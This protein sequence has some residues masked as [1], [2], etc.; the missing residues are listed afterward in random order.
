MLLT[1]DFAFLAGVEQGKLDEPKYNLP[2]AHEPLY[3][4]KPLGPYEP[5]ILQNFE[6]FRPD[7]NKPVRT[8]FPADVKSQS[9]LRDT[10]KQGHNN[11]ITY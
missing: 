2:S 8:I 5:G 10:T 6:G 7:P 4:T 11:F 1:L 3:V 9:E